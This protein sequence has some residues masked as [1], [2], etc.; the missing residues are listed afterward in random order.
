MML[1]IYIK[2]TKVKIGE[3]Y[4]ENSCLII[5]P[6][7]PTYEKPLKMLIESVK[8]EEYFDIDVPFP[9]SWCKFSKV[10][11]TSDPYYLQ[12]LERHITGK[13]I[14]NLE[15]TSVIKHNS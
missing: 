10:P 2:G 15:V 7:K 9:F 13:R 5:N 3:V 6:Q 4:V 1:E 12:A 11:K 8:N 14:G